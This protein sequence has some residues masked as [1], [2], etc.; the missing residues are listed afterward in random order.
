MY[1]QIERQMLCYKLNN[2]FSGLVKPS[3]CFVNFTSK[4]LGMNENSNVYFEAY[5][6][7]AQRRLLIFQ[8]R[9]AFFVTV[10]L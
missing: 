3:L 1:N 10:H 5:Q 7:L 6:V 4:K 2:F 9:I 8:K